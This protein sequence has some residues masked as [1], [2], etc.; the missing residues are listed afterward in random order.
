MANYTNRIASLES[1]ELRKV[2]LIY[3]KS[4]TGNYDDANDLVQDTYLRMLDKTALYTEKGKLTSWARIMMKHHFCNE[5][6]KQ[7]N[8]TLSMTGREYILES[9]EQTTTDEPEC[10]YFKK[11]ITRLVDS[12]PARD[13]RLLHLRMEGYKYEEIGEIF[14]MPLGTVR[15]SIFYAK[16]KLLK[17]LSGYDEFRLE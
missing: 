13:A 5:I 16:N 10:V 1:P 4:L 7:E 9:E 17:K 15:S 14:S 2:L 6:K 12:L 11:E 8:N 3:A